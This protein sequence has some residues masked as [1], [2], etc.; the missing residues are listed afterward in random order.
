MI[1]V[2]VARPS[3][4]GH[5]I[6]STATVLTSA[7]IVSPENH[8]CR[9]ESQQRDTD[10]DR[11]ENARDPIGEPRD[12]RLRALRVAHQPDDARE[13]CP[14]RRRRWRHTAAVLLIDCSGEDVDAT[15]VLSTG[16]LSPVSILR[17]LSRSRR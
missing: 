1:A 10:D 16:R 12:R 17:R 3:A 11:H 8:Q 9:E 13:Q 5:A 2:G 15:A 7:P 14:I 4:Q 6:T